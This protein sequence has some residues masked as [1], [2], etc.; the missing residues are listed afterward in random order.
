MP[1]LIDWNPEMYENI[2]N[3]YQLNI[4]GILSDLAHTELNLSHPSLDQ[5]LQFSVDT[6]QFSVKFQI[7]LGNNPATNENFYEVV[8]LTNEV[9]SIQFGSKNEAL[10]Q[11]FQDNVPTIWFADGSQ[12]FGNLFVKLKSQP[13]V[14][15]QESIIAD[16]WLGVNIE[17]EAQDISPYIQDSIQYYFIEKIKNDFQIIYD[18]DGKGEIADIIGINDMGDVIDVHLYHLKYASEGKISN[19]ID[20]FYQVAGRHKKL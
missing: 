16:D 3:R 8:Q 4:N 17:K 19:N 10:L 13:D 1:V 18:D 11:F 6:D 14:I 5:P 15:P 12:L 9:C 20:N 2:E 7:N